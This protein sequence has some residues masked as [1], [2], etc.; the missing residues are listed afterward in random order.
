VGGP[1]S[2]EEK[3]YFAASPINFVTASSP[4]TLLVHGSRDETIPADQS[5]RLDT[6]LREAGVKHVF[7]TLPW[8][9]HG[10]DKSFG[11]PCGQITMFAVERFL[12]AVT[13]PSAAASPARGRNAK[14]LARR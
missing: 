3:A 9:T 5:A 8:A 6:R 14:R 10:C 13:I 7:A 1:P 4:P 2:R 12:D 11:G